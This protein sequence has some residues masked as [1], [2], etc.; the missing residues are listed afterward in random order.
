MLPSVP[1]G[2]GIDI[3]ENERMQ[4]VLQ[5]WG[6]KFK[7]R[8]FLPEEQEYCESRSM[9]HIH[10]AVRFAAKE[11]VAKALHLGFGS[12]IRWTDIHIANNPS[13]GEPSVILKGITKN[14]A[15]A[16]NID[17]ILISLSH[18][19]THSIATAIAFQKI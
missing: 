12:T 9:P 13:T 16:M 15:T 7:N 11:A 1:A 6:S 10:Y 18:C 5:R 4:K 2:I 17:T 19:H 8:V 3:I 14:T